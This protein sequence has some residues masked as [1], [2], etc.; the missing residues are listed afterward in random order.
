MPWPA[1][2]LLQPAACPH[3]LPARPP[4]AAIVCTH[5]SPPLVLS[6]RC[7]LPCKLPPCPPIGWSRPSSR[8]RRW[9]TSARS[10]S[11][12]PPDGT[13]PPAPQIWTPLNPA[14]REQSNLEGWLQKEPPLGRIGQVSLPPTVPAVSASPCASGRCCARSSIA[15]PPVPLQVLALP[16]DPP[17]LSYVALTNLTNQTPCLPSL[18]LQPTN[19]CKQQQQQQRGRPSRDLIA[20]AALLTSP[21]LSLCVRHPSSSS[22]PS[23][24][25][26]LLTAL[27]PPSQF[28]GRS[29]LRPPP[30]TSS[31]P[32]R[33]RPS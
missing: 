30:A 26:P 4:P 21:T 2:S 10:A 13:S 7:G 5:A 32:P 23:D 20:P 16:P 25:K 12:Q 22:P 29:P 14:S 31:W 24:S 9:A 6:S 15:A 11:R 19:V 1:A 8:P 28:L 27:L 3:G 18:L 17:L 33:R